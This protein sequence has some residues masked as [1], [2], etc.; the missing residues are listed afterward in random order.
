VTSFRWTRLLLSILGWLLTSGPGG[1]A[2]EPAAERIYVGGTILT[3]NDSQPLVEAVAVAKGRIVAVGSRADV[4]AYR[5][6]KTEVI[7]LAG[8][9]LVPGFI[10]G[11]SHFFSLVDVQTQA[12]CASP[13][14]GP[15][16]SVADVIAALERIKERRKIGPGE[17]VMGFGCDPD[18]LAE[19]RFPTKAELDRAFPDNPVFIVHVSG[20]GAK[21]NSKALAAYSITA[22]TPTPVGGVIGREAGSREP[23][24]LLFETAFMP[25][26][27][28]LPSPGDDE[29][30]SILES[31]QDLYLRAGITTA[32]EGATMKHQLD[33]LRVFADRGGL[34]LD[35]V[36]LPFITEIDAVFAGK[37]PANEPESRNTAIAS[38][39]GASRSSPTA[40]HRERRPPS[41]RPTSPTARR[42][43]T[44]GVESCH[45]L[46]ARSTTG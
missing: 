23:D 6:E 14:A 37:P 26:F 46:K 24:G 32:Q 30:L 40:H 43:R 8:R 34:K 17:F 21:L 15:C 25:I 28:K 11:H 13:P 42:G 27:A 5:G 35:L 20:H 3:V 33:L 44:A 41:P 7:D 9:T 16:R 1:L 4:L 2:A 38:G 18:L 10:D 22:A 36:A 29:L 39:S 31:G 45:S 12:L 19:K